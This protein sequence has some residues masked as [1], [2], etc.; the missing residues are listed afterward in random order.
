MASHSNLIPD[1]GYTEPGFVAARPGLHGELQFTFR[2][3][4]IQDQAKWV[5]GADSMQAAVWNQQ[6]ARL[7]AERIKS[8]SLCTKDGSCVPINA[9]SILRLKP[10]LFSRLYGILL[11]TE[12]SDI[13]PS[14][15]ESQLATEAE[16][17]AAAI[18]NAVSI[19]EARETVYGGN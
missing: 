17:A 7:M 16:I 5:K 9:A 1:D 6:C 15:E 12:P 2:P 13:D 11:G 3:L 8:W 10:A 18:D 14:W 4:L 19:G